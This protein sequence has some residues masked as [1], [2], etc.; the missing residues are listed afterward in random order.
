MLLAV[1]TPGDEGCRAVVYQG[2]GAITYAEG[3]W[4]QVRGSLMKAGL[5]VGVGAVS[6]PISSGARPRLPPA[7]REGDS[8]GEE[9]VERTVVKTREG[10]QA[11][12][13]D[14]P[15]AGL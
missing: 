3:T 4:G 13:V 8:F 5:A 9:P 6:A 11:V 2:R 1:I 10:D 14:E 7:W 15:L 12:Q